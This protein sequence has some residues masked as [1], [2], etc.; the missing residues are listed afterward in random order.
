MLKVFDKVVSEAPFL[1]HSTTTEN[2]HKKYLL[3]LYFV[4]FSSLFFFGY[5]V[6]KQLFVTYVMAYIIVWIYQFFNK[7]LFFNSLLWHISV[8]SYVLILSPQISI[9]SNILGVIIMMIVG[10]SVLSVQGRPIISPVLLG[11]LAGSTTVSTYMR[12][13]TFTLFYL[14]PMIQDANTILGNPS[15][16]TALI[17]ANH[18]IAEIP[19]KAFL[20][21]NSISAYTDLIKNYTDT[22]VQSS[23][24]LFYMIIS[25]YSY[26]IGIGSI[27]VILLAYMMLSFS[28]IIDFIVP[29][30]YSLI[31]LLI[32]YLQLMGTSNAMDILMQRFVY[33][34][35]LWFFSVFVVASCIPIN[36]KRGLYCATIIT[37]IIASMM[38]F[39]SHYIINH[40]FAAIIMNIS[41]SLIEI[42]CKKPVFGMQKLTSNIFK[43]FQSRF[44]VSKRYVIRISIGL[45]MIGSVFV[46]VSFLP[47]DAF[48]QRED[49]YFSHIVGDIFPD[50]R[51]QKIDLNKN[52]FQAE[53]NQGEI[54]YIINSDSSL[55]RTY[56]NILI[57]VKDNIVQEVKVVQLK[58]AH[59]YYIDK[60]LRQLLVG[61]D[62]NDMTEIL[63][64]TAIEKYS[65]KN[66]LVSHRIVDAFRKGSVIYS[67]FVKNKGI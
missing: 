63:N 60:R 23:E 53:D 35:S 42:I 45:L 8:V 6:L 30:L 26:N 50:Y 12:E 13:P 18:I 43:N 2:Q 5:S 9:Y 57:L 55:Y 40:V 20:Y 28:K 61:K 47:N 48:K 46:S 10:A 39:R 65:S 62:I 21:S 15:F 4:L 41:A 66:P 24:N 34:L 31:F 38:F 29:I 64:D 7:T 16:L 59:S 32:Y 3:I 14:V 51:V 1:H 67:E 33:D 37:A 25:P 36:N 27:F 19:E 58:T 54:S 17:D 22:L 11:I 49:L 44:R 52:I 56:I